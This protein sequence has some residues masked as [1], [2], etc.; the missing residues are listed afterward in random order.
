VAGESKMEFDQL[1]GTEVMEFFRILKVYERNLKKK[2]E[3]AT[4]KHGKNTS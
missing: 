4:K 2:L 1:K 3:K